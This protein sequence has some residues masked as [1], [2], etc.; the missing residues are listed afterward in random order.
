MKYTPREY[1]HLATTHI[2]E[3]PRCALLAKPGMGKTVATLAALDAIYLAGET[4][5]TLIL[6]PKRVAKHTWPKEVDKWADFR[7]LET[8][9]IVGDEEQRLAALAKD[10]PLYST[11]YEQIPWLLDHFGARWPFSTVIADEATKLKNLRISVRQKKD[12]TRYLH[13]EKGGS[14]RASRLV[15]EAAFHKNTTRFIC[16]TGTPVSNGLKDLW[17]QMFFLDAGRRLGRSYG[18]FEAR[19]FE[20]VMRHPRDKFGELRPRPGASE[21]INARIA[22]LCLALEPRDWFPDLQEPLHFKVVVELPAKARELYR[23]MEKEMYIEIER[24][25]IEAFNVSSMTMKCRQLAAGAIYTDIETKAWAEVHDEKIQALEDIYEESGGMPLLVAYNFKSDLARLLKA[26]PTG[27]DLST[28]EGLKRFLAGEAPYGFGHPASIGY[29][30]DGM[31]EV[32]C[33]IVFFS[34]DFNLEYREQIIERIGPMRQLQSGHNRK[35]LIYDIVADDTIDETVL[36]RLE[37]K[38]SVQEALFDAMK[39]KKSCAAL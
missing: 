32:S 5:P 22:D 27:A 9:A 6:A 35:V 8:S 11:N 15:K 3:T 26:F 33:A 19:W 7:H 2:V 24:V 16:L 1:G 38:C 36:F 17:G 30:F 31:Q 14:S 4:K 39:R 34:S 20:R 37:N 28:D 23:K 21:E 18:A 10:V 13:G 29:G 12:G 25:V